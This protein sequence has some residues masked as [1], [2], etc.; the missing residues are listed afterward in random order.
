[1]DDKKRKYAKFLL[2]RCLSINAGEPLLLSY[3]V[4]QEEFT[5]IV[6]EEA[7]KLGVTEI[8]DVC[9]DGKKTRDILNSSTLEE[10]KNNPYFDR[11]VIKDVYDKGGSLLSLTSYSNPTLNDVPQEKKKLMN[12]IKVDTQ[13]DAIKARK[14]Y[15][16]PWCIA[17][18]ATKPWAEELFPGEENNLEKLWKLILKCNLMDK[19]DPIKAQE[20]KIKRNT[21]TKNLLNELKLKKLIYKNNLGTNLEIELPNNANWLGTLKTTFDGKKEI[22]V[23][24]PTNEVFAAPNKNK[25]DGVV[26]TSKPVMIS[27]RIVDRIK[28]D[29][30]DG[31][32]VKIEASN[33]QE[34][35]EKF[36]NNTKN[37]NRLGECALVD[38]SS[39][40]AKIDVLFKQI[41]VDENRACHIA[42]GNAYP[43]NIINGENMTEEELEMAGLNVCTNH[44]DLMIGTSDLSIIGTDIYGNEVPIF[45]DG[46]FAE[47]KVVEFIKNRKVV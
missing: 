11:K 26:V 29:F 39:E 47:E 17:A 6:K 38:N 33:E 13:E 30:K 15:K 41:L 25:V 10:I 32:V 8:Y 40:I 45:V 42:L 4:E 24:A 3:L 37:L 27:G 1:M 2:K 46:D 31:E 22:I 21:N 36:I 35:L 14:I 43:K 9:Y 34:F 18:V 23:N 19:E 5:N 28:L 16:F 44:I 7:K 20:E 12:K